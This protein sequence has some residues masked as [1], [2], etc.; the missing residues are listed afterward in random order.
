MASIEFCPLKVSTDYCFKKYDQLSERVTLDSE[1]N[2]GRKRVLLEEVSMKCIA[3]PSFD[4]HRS[5]NL[6]TIISSTSSK[7]NKIIY[8][9]KSEP[10]PQLNSASA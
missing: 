9:S 5:S 8:N 3:R 10:M 1:Q 6:I 7:S 2:S 4:Q